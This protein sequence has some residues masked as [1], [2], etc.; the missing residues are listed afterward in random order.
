M[1]QQACCDSQQGCWGLRIRVAEIGY[2]TFLREFPPDGDSASHL[3]SYSL[4][5]STVSTTETCWISSL[6]S[7]STENGTLRSENFNVR[8]CWKRKSSYTSQVPVGVER[9]HWKLNLLVGLI[10]LII[11]YDTRLPNYVQVGV[12]MDELNSLD[13]FVNLTSYYI[14]RQWNV[15]NIS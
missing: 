7:N 6:I 1:T 2:G 4:S 12:L 5:P 8:N 10:L 15:F 3:A 14:W 13:H 11:V 9:L